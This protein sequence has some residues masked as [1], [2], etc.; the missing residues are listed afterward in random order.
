MSNEFPSV[1]CPFFINAKGKIITCEILSG[2]LE[3]RTCFPDKKQAAQW[4]EKYCKTFQYSDCE[5]A[6]RILQRHE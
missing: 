6:E 4:M 2:R 3:A 5:I 1:I